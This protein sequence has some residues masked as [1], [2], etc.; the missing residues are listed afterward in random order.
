MSN[1]ELTPTRLRISGWAIDPDDRRV[2]PRIPASI[3]ASIDG[4]RDFEHIAL[5]RNASRTG[6]LLITNH[7]CRLEQNLELAFQIFGDQYGTVVPA[8]VVRVGGRGDDPMWKFD[9]GVQFAEPLADELLAE[10]E[11]RAG[12]PA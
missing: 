6:A 5:I 9:V 11:K 8:R 7:P 12:I 10:I 3:P 1:I 4:Q 2:E